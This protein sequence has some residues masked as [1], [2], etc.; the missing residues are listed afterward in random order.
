M[1]KTFVSNSFARFAGLRLVLLSPTAYAV[2]YR[3]AARF[4]SFVVV[5]LTL[6]A[7]TTCST[8][9]GEEVDTTAIPEVTVAKVQR[10]RLQTKIVVNGNLA[11][12]P[13]RDA[14]LAPLVPGRIA[15]VLVTE[16]D[17]VSAGQVLAELENAQLK[18]Q[19]RQAEAAVAQAEANLENARASAK[20]NENLLQRG[21]AARKEV[22]DARTQLAVSEAAHRQ[23]SAAFSVAKSQ[24]GRA[25]IRAPFAGTVVRRFLGVGDQV[26]GSGGQPVVE[27]AAIEAL[28]LLGTVPANRL[29]DIKTGETFKFT[30]DA[31]PGA[32][33]EARV[34]AALPAVDPATN[35]GTVR[36]RI[37]NPKRLLK[38][39]QYLSLELPSKESS[40]RLVVPK[41]AIYPGESGE[42]HVYV[43]KGEEADMVP[44]VVGAQ[45][46]EQAEIISGV[47]D[48][49]SVIVNGGYG[50]PE[51]SK[52]RV[53]GSTAQ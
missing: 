16:G 2:G 30:T 50:L 52:V 49:D 39:G 46:G 3:S 48:G 51:K 45:T 21:I 14:K 19:E 53:K 26:D 6:V 23:A 29:N 40:P 37:Q 15:R 18:D 1:I 43:V 8:H 9:H 41:Q 28:E 5:L 38:L 47:S 22:E 33:F 12:L 11:G 34:V 10:V 20:R 17:R 25:E 27:V 32:T 42:P 24:L 31:A 7:L 35:N 13:N 44:V 4:A 36:V